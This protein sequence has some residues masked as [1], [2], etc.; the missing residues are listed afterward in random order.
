MFH[1]PVAAFVDDHFAA[2]HVLEPEG[3]AQGVPAFGIAVGQPGVMLVGEVGT[4]ERQIVLTVQTA[5]KGG[6]QVDPLECKVFD[7]GNVRAAQHFVVHAEVAA[8]RHDQ[9]PAGFVTGFHMFPDPVDLALNNG[10]QA[11]LAG[12]FNTFQTVLRGEVGAFPVV[13]TEIVIAAFLAEGF[14]PL[15]FG[16]RVHQAGIDAAF[17][18]FADEP[19]KPCTET[20]FV[21]L[22]NIFKARHGEVLVVFPVRSGD[23][24][25]DLIQRIEPVRDQFRGEPACN[26]P[27]L[28]QV[29]LI[30][31]NDLFDL[32]QNIEM[33]CLPGVV[34]EHGA[35]EGIGIG[36]IDPGSHIDPFGRQ[37]QLGAFCRSGHLGGGG[38]FYGRFLRGSGFFCRCGL[39]GCGLCHFLSSLQWFQF[40]VI[41]ML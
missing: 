23:V 21:L 37:F 4:P 31:V 5:G 16:F 12:L 14:D 24:D 6:R 39:L 40:Q 19:D 22:K 33:L 7:H 11:A 3:G 36:G 25:P 9:T 20:V 10:A 38:F 34:P 1:E 35:E 29:A 2:S 15:G 28:R 27:D 26:A 32:F 17:L 8:G 41:I 13:V 30:I 18:R